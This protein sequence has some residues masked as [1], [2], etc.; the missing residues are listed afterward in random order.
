MRSGGWRGGGVGVGASARCRSGR[1][2]TRTGGDD[3][4]GS[5]FPHPV[6]VPLSSPDIGGAAFGGERSGGYPSSGSGGGDW[7]PRSLLDPHRGWNDGGGGEE[8]WAP[9]EVAPYESGWAMQLEAEA[10]QRQLSAGADGGAPVEYDPLQQRAP[11]RPSASRLAASPRGARP[12]APRRPS[13]GGS[14][15]PSVSFAVR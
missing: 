8:A 7:R 13:T 9:R 4:W 14:R 15:R 11:R 10:Q 2:T 1:I 3:V 5:H 6:I 12:Q